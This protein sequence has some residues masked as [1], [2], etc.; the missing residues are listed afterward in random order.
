M[1]T[2]TEQSFVVHL[3]AKKFVQLIFVGFEKKFPAFDQQLPA[4]CSVFLLLFDAE[5]YLSLESVF[6]NVG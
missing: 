6:T 4:K 5:Q 1:I 3:T 2:P